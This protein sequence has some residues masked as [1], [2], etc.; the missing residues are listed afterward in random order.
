MEGCNCPESEALIE[1]TTENCGVNM[2]QI[3][4]I[5]VQRN[6]PDAFTPTTILTLAAWQAFKTATDSTKIVFTPMIG[7]D[8]VIEPGEA[9]T[10]GGG[11][12]STLNGIAEID[13][14][15]PSNFSAM[16]KSLTPKVEAQIKE[17]MCEKNLTVYFFLQGGRIACWQNDIL[18]PATSP[19]SGIPVSSVFL[20]DRAVAGFGAKDTNMFS[21]SME[22]GW[23]EKLFIIK[24]NFNPFTDL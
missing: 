6:T 2:N 17:L 22:A 1:I 8:P 9:I 12:N 13:G 19:N 3:Q 4:R 24:P 5:G 11:D 21:F 10:T 16:F 20:G 15:N 23:S 18:T 7:G 14:V